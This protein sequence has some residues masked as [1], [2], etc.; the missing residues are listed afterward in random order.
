MET[1]VAPVSAFAKYIH[2][3]DLPA[4]PPRRR[5]RLQSAGADDDRP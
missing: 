2:F 3:L 4:A 5:S 1:R